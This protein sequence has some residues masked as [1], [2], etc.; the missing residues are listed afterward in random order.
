MASFGLWA[1][2]LDRYLR[3]LPAEQVASAC[4]GF[5]EDLAGLLRGVAAI[6]GSTPSQEVPRF[7]MFEALAVLVR[8]LAATAPLIIALDDLHHADGSSWEVLN[9]LAHNL[10][11]TRVLIVGA[12]RRA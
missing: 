2:A 5:L 1:E 8:N 9:Y 10:P 3:D 12:A 11:E 6:Y 7:R 4:G